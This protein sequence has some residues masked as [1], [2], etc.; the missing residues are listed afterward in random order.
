MF[1]GVVLQNAR[2][3]LLKKGTDGGNVENNAKHPCA[4]ARNS[5]SLNERGFRPASSQVEF[6]TALGY[7]VGLR[8]KKNFKKEG[9]G[10][11]QLF[12]K[13]QTHRRRRTGFLSAR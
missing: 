12:L 4:S 7:S 3:L 1:R 6:A 9:E 2:F 13:L 10:T 8:F 5:N 11:V